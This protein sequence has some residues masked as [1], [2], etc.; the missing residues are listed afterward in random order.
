MIMIGKNKILK[1]ACSKQSR[2]NYKKYLQIEG[3]LIF[4]KC[5]TILIQLSNKIET[6]YQ[7]M[8]K[9]RLWTRKIK[10]K[11]L[12]LRMMTSCK[13]NKQSLVF[14]KILISSKYQNKV[15][16]VWDLTIYQAHTSNNLTTLIQPEEFPTL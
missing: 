12:S 3:P 11:K 1:K 6:A 7:E 13:E 5:Q 14:I 8:F 9:I 4:R 2:M 10:I 15:H 16:Q